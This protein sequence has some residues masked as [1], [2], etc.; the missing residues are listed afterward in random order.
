LNWFKPVT[1]SI[2]PFFLHHYTD[3]LLPI[4]LITFTLPIRSQETGE[5]RNPP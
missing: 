2:F 3:L 4:P 5:T 1:F